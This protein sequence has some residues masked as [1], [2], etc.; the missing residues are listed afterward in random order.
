MAKSA[1]G[2]AAI[3]KRTELNR[4]KEVHN[5]ND[6]DSQLSTFGAVRPHDAQW[7]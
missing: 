3:N 5:G 1:A 4:F 7:L 6:N 2:Q